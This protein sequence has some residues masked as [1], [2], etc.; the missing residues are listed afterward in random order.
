MATSKM[1]FNTLENQFLVSMPQLND[2]YFKQS[3]ILIC[4]HD[5]NGAVGIIINHITEHTIGDIFK[6]LDIAEIH[7]QFTQQ[8]VLSGGPV[9]PELGLVI[10]NDLSSRWESSMEIG[11]NLRF[12]SSRDILEAM[13]EGRGPEQATMSLGYAGWAAGQLED[14]IQQNSWFT[15]PVDHEILFSHGQV[16]KWQMAA[17]LLGIDTNKFSSQVGHA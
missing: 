15:T 7:N 9:Y 5:E 3:V 12:T 13:A 17:Q 10:H 6:Q 16:D 11:K 14:E 8:P 2:P 1:K 4:K